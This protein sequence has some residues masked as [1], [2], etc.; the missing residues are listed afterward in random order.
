MISNFIDI[1]KRSLDK[2]APFKKKYIPGN[3]LPFMN[4]KLYKA[5][6]QNS[7]T[8]FCDIGPMKIVKSI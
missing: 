2:H 8:I 7:V 4:R 6:G 3:H 5:I 1:C